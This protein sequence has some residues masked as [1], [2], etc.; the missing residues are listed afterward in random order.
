MN[1]LPALLIGLA[2]LLLCI[3]LIVRVLS[4]GEE[5]IG[6]E[7][8]AKARAALDSILIKTASIKRILSE[9]DLQFACRAGSRELKAL[10]VK[11]RKM[12]VLHWFRTVQQQVAYLM[13]V[14]LRL[15]GTTS[16]SA[17]SELRLTGQYW[18]FVI[19]CSALIALFWL[20]GPFH[21]R[22]TLGYMLHVVERFFSTFTTRL[23]GISATQRP[24][25]QSL[26]H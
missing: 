9:E 18:T 24:S 10:F 17:R 14:H 20:S 11:E 21:A 2:V 6:P 13:S 4:K 3:R 16:P 8:F 7:D 26:V 5:P 15:A 25:P 23:E 19:V 12:L 1:K 22:R